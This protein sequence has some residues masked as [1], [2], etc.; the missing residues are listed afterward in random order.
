[1]AA[2]AAAAPA[3]SNSAV[4]A[5]AAAAATAAGAPT[6]NQRIEQLQQQLQK[7]RL[8]H[9]AHNIAFTQQL[10]A[11]AA[12][13]DQLRLAQPQP[14]PLPTGQQR[15]QLP[16]PLELGKGTSARPWAKTASGR[17]ECGFDG[18]RGSLWYFCLQF[19]ASMSAGLEPTML[20]SDQPL[21]PLPADASDEEILKAAY[22]YEFERRANNDM[23]L[24]TYIVLSCGRRAG[25]YLG[26]FGG[27]G[28]GFKAWQ[29]LLCVFQAPERDGPLTNFV[30]GRHRN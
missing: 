9:A 12:E 22:H 15:Q 11:L 23:H 26:G 5:T 20:C 19:T 16:P 3:W 2:A 4:P 27:P 17:V 1:M 30:P 28:S 13:L 29:R 18:R 25:R 24:Y 8:A 21:L 10:N 6:P 7:L 14:A